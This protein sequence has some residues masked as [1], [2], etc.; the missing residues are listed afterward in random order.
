MSVAR[1]GEEIIITD[2]NRPVARLEPVD[3]TRKP[4]VPGRLK[5][6]LKVPER[7]FDPL[8]PEELERWW[9]ERV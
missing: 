3:D 1:E 9:G 4:R 2:G 6:K 5:G 7:L 8:P